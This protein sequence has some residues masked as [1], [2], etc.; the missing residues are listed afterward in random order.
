MGAMVAGSVGVSRG[1]RSLGRGAGAGF[2]VAWFMVA[3]V[4]C[5]STSVAPDGGLCTSDDECPAGEYC[6]GGLCGE[7]VDAAESG[8]PEIEVAPLTLD[9]GNAPLGESVVHELA[10]ANVGDAPLTVSRIELIEAD[11]LVEYTA[12]PS[13]PITWVVE[14][15]EVVR[16]R[17]MLVQQDGEIDRGELRVSSDDADE[18]FV[19]VLLLSDLKGTPVLEVTPGELDFGVVPWGDLATRRVDISNGGTGNAPLVLTALDV[20]D[21]TGLGAAYSVAMAL[22]DPDSGVETPTLLPVNLAADGLLLRASVTVDTSGLVGGALPAEALM[23]SWQELAPGTGERAIPIL[24]AVLGCGAPSL[25]ECNGRDDDCDLEVDEGALG[26]GAACVSTLPGACSAGTERCIDGAFECVAVAAPSVEACN[27]VDDDCDGESDESL[28]RPCS[29][30]CGAGVEFC[31]VG[32]WLGCNAPSPTPEACD[33][34]DNDC[35]GTVDEGNPGGGAACTTAEFGACAAGMLLCGG[36][37][38]LCR[39]VREPVAE[40]CNAVDDDCDGLLDD[41][42]PGAGIAC[43]TGQ[44]GVCAPG[45]TE[46]ALGFI[47]CAGSVLP[48]VETCNGLD[49][50]CDGF[51]DDG[52]AAGGSCDGPD[53]DLCAEGTFVCMAGMPLCNDVGATN[54]ELCNGLDDDCN[55]VTPDGADDAAIGVECDGADSDLCLEGAWICFG[56]GLAC[57]DTTGSTAELCNG[58]DDDCDDGSLDGSE[59]P[60]AG[61]ACDGPDG[62]LCAEGVRLCAVGAIACSD[63]TGTVVESC[64]GLDDDCDGINDDGGD[65]LC[66]LGPRVALAACGG[67]LGCAITA[68]DG[69]FADCDGVYGD[70][71]EANLTSTSTCGACGVVCGPSQ[72]CSGGVCTARSECNDGIDNDGDGAIDFPA[73][74]S[75]TLPSDNDE[76][77]T[78]FGSDAFGYTGCRDT[79]PLTASPCPDIRGSGTVVCSNDDCT[80]GVSI[81]FAFTFYGV[82]HS[83]FSVSSNGKIGFPTSSIYSNGC[84]IETN[85]IAAYWDDLYPPTGGS[86]RSQTVGVA[87]NRSFVVNWAVPHISGGSVYDIRAALH[88][89]S[90]AIEYCYLETTTLNASFDLGASATVGIMGPSGVGLPYSCNMPVITE[91]LRLRFT[92]P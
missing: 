77:C 18:P 3:L 17:V 1:V 84:T 5:G 27:G 52:S 57:D 69:G 76:S 31:A 10:I 91:G 28:I 15:A 25:E 26:G 88:E 14:P 89:G 37:T 68:C 45:V 29:S 81:P 33:E 92:P 30:A 9:F 54:L 78:S 74:S 24:G 85:N 42:A 11:S 20:T 35:D 7:P 58:V 80:A 65:A 73:D 41:G 46:C 16:V 55:P 23:I 19:P 86:V 79:F 13:G 61:G 34:V 56:G 36:G 39:R 50:D 62:D 2:V 44:P 6:R 38:L 63:A 21:D 59:D 60:V 64:N 43:V 82:S 90:N 87:P 75:C 70:G 83:S 8:A 49:D 4:A 40:L 66:L 72:T 53:G 47:R 67:A 71:C 12:E 48:S 22:V 32:N 51:P